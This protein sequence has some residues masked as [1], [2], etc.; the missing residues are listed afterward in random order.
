VVMVVAVGRRQHV[1]AARPVWMR[2]KETEI[3]IAQR[4]MPQGQMKEALGRGTRGDMGIKP[5]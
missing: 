3:L 2:R 5:W 1:E 4:Q